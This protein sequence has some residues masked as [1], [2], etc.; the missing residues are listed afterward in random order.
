MFEIVDNANIAQTQVTDGMNP[1][2]MA[3]LCIFVYIILDL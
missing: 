1:S 2:S 3:D